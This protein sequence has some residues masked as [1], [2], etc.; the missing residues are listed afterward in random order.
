MAT[1][2][3]QNV[4]RRCLTLRQKIEVIREYE[5]GGRGSRKLA[6]QFGVGKTQ[7]ENIVKR[8][9]EYLDDFAN[10]VPETKRRNCTTG[11]EQ[12]NELCLRFYRDRASRGKSCNGPMLQGA[13]LTFAKDLG[14]TSFKA[15]N[16]WLEC[17]KRRHNIS[18]R[19]KPSG[20]DRVDKAVVRTPRDPSTTGE[21]IS[22][23]NW[24]RPD[25]GLSKESTD[26]YHLD[27]VLVSDR[28][29]KELSITSVHVTSGNSD[30]NDSNAESIATAEKDQ[31]NG[32]EESDLPT[33][34]LPDVATVKKEPEEG[35]NAMEEDNSLED[36]CT[37][38][39]NNLSMAIKAVNDL[40][41]YCLNEG[42]G[43]E[44]FTLSELENRFISLW[45]ER[46][47]STATT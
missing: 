19:S 21:H 36:I 22:P 1:V 18:A 12:I 15:S 9:R 10:N 24:E 40:K 38:P 45:M 31:A 41:L 3:R 28:D 46:R 6:K 2:T 11:Y 20:G 47:T 39:I 32:G 13:A 26:S 44:L 23:E 30:V 8:K 34:T 27:D 25:I 37:G 14:V 35:E 16:G 5:K 4:K 29:Q 43:S 7:I 42:L 33:E 17:F